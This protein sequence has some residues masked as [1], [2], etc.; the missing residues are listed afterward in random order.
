MKTYT[1]YYVSW[2]LKTGEATYGRSFDTEAERDKFAAD[3][4]PISTSVQTWESE[5]V[6]F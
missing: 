2:S 1:V 5:C 6:E 3:M 4:K